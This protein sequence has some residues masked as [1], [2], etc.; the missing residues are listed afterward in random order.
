MI[1]QGLVSIIIPVYNRP[2]YLLDCL[3][4]ISLQTYP[5]IE[6]I[7]IDDGSTISMEEMVQN[8]TWP[9]IYSVVYI[10]LEQNRGPGYA[11]EVGRQKATGIYISYMDSDDVIHPE[12]ISV[13]VNKLIEFPNVGMVYCVTLNFTNLPFDDSETIRSSRMVENILP[14]VLIDRPW[15]T[16][17]CLWTKEATDKIGPWFPGRIKEDTL[18]EVLAGCLNIEIRYIPKILSYYRIHSGQP[19]QRAPSQQ[20][21]EQ[22]VLTLHEILNLLHFYG[23]LSDDYSKIA[24]SNEIFRVCR[25][26]FILNDPEPAF[27][28]LEHLSLLNHTNHIKTSYFNYLCKIILFL[29]LILPSKTYPITFSRLCNFGMLIQNYKN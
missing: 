16:S 28:I 24:I 13:Q 21:Y 5:K 27:E 4:S 14:S 10:K 3:H 29:R 18:Y 19:E 6:V 1:S 2:E 9:K 11:R 12:K 22:A 26:L 17:S 20:K 15:S 7:I 8:I 25:K 23:K